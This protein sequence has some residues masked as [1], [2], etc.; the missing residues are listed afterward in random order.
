MV[1][2]TNRCRASKSDGPSL[3]AMLLLS[4]TTI[5]AVLSEFVSSDFDRVYDAL[6][7]RPLNGRSLAVSQR[8]L[9]LDQPMLAVSVMLPSAPPGRIALLREIV[10][11]GRTPFTNWLMFRVM[12]RRSP[13][14]P[15]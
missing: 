3:A 6:N 4:C 5:V 1:L 13:C 12:R 14:D 11:N 9:Q 10:G 8:A 7:W 2:M 15:K